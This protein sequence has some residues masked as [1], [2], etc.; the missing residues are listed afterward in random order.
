[1]MSRAESTGQ[2]QA[3]VAMFGTQQSCRRVMSAREGQ[4]ASVA[5]PSAAGH[6]NR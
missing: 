5:A 3:Q 4:R 6:G 2:Q 1:M